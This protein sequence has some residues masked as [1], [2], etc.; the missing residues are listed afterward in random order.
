M[1]LLGI[2]PQ[3]PDPEYGYIVPGKAINDGDLGAR[4]VRLF[5]EKPA[6]GATKKI[7]QSGALC[8]TFVIVFRCRTLMS[9]IQQTAPELYRS[10]QPI[11][12]AIGT[13]GEQRVT[14]RVYENLAPL[15]FST[16]VLEALPS[17]LREALTVL[18]VSGITWDDWGTPARLS[19]AM[20]HLGK[21]GWH[22]TA[23]PPE[24]QKAVGAF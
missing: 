20:Q 14:D 24:K 19:R 18:P 8:N 6:L 9:I 17:G 7:V 23:R 4:R 2:T 10:F 3:E 21:A 16:G 1:V 12:E 15:N 5:V 13:R 22:E 11:L